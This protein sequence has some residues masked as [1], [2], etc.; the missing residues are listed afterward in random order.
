VLEAGANIQ[1]WN[2]G[3]EQPAAVTAIDTVAPADAVPAGVAMADVLVQ[4]RLVNVYVNPVRASQ[5]PRLLVLVPL[6]LLSRTHTAT[7]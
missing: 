2:C 3:L 1:S 5:W 6:L 4:G 7:P